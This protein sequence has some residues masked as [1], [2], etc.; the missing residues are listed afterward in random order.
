VAGDAALAEVLVQAHIATAAML[1]IAAPDSA[2][3]PKMMEIARTLNPAVEIVVRTHSEE[4]AAALG[5]RRLHQ[6]KLPR[7]T[8][9][10]RRTSVDLEL[11]LWRTPGCRP[12]DLQASCNARS[13]V[14]RVPAQPQ[15]QAHTVSLR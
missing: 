1:V 10:S 7:R 3:T 13:R 2:G 6:R 14:S 4:V 8:M 11:R 9:N 15:W 5:G 12:R